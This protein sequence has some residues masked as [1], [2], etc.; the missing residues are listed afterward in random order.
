MLCGG[1][2]VKACGRDTA[3]V[4]CMFG[5]GFA[6]SRAMSWMSNLA[7]PVAMQTGMPAACHGT[8]SV[9]HV[10]LLTSALVRK[11]NARTP[12]EAASVATLHI[13]F[14][15]ESKVPNSPSHP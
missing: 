9:T 14:G 7:L 6:V 1:R 11:K 5:V 13:K 8:Q 10:K 4:C 15:T 12:Q 3:G 2:G